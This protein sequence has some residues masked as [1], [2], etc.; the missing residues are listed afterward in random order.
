MHQGSCLCGAIRY[1]I[2][3]ELSEFGYCHCSSCRKASGSAFAA[4]VSV[5][6]EAFD[7]TSG[8]SHLRS[9]ESSPGKHRHFCGVC[10]S[11]LF[12]KVG[13]TP[14]VVRIRLGCL[15]TAFTERPKAHIFVGEKAGWAGLDEGV[16]AYETWP[17][18]DE[19]AIEGSRQ[20]RVR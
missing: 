8:A 12:T 14:S 18:P 2:N 1:T 5:P 11:P 6:V 7:V 17:D 10:A 15:D 4:N 19:V 20:P 16:S 3:G 13:D 9:F